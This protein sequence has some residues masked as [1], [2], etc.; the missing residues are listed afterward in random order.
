MA[1]F[2]NQFAVDVKSHYNEQV[3][4]FAGLDFN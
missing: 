2:I 4:E 3:L 1:L